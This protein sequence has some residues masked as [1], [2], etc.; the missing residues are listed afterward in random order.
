MNLYIYG[1]GGNGCEICDLANTINHEKK[2]W[3]AIHFVDD[4]RQEREW[5][6]HSVYRFDSMLLDPE[7]F[8]CVIS[9]GEPLHR[10]TLYEKLVAHQVQLATL[11]SPSAVVSNS[12]T[13]GPGSIVGTRSY[14]SSNTVLAANIMLEVQSIIGHDISI[15]KHSVISSCSVIGGATTIGEETFIG[16][17]CCVKDKIS[18]GNH[19]ILGMGSCLFTNIDSGLIALGNPARTVKKNEDRIVFK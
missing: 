9:L 15:G 16:M 19:S 8:E 5:Y 7:P 13:I 6:G 3:N 18:I 2:R 17:N 1:S 14:V 11:V 12:A 10:K 4:V